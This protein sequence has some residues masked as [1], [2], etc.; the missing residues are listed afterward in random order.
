VGAQQ[1]ANRKSKLVKD[2]IFYTSQAKAECVVETYTMENIPAF[3]EEDYMTS[4]N[5][6]LSAIRYE[7]ETFRD[8]RGNVE[9]YSKSWK[10]V[11]KDFKFGEGTG[12]ES[13]KTSYFKNF[14]SDD[15][16]A[17]PNTVE[18]AKSV[19]YKLQDE[20][21]W[22]KKNYIFRDENVK[23]AYET[24]SGST[25]ELNLILLNFLN[26]S[27][28]DAQFMVLSTRENGVPTKLYPIISEFNYLVVK[29][30]I[31]GSTY[32]LDITDKHTPFGTLPFKTLNGYGRVMDFKE[33]SYWYDFSANVE[34]LQNTIIQFDIESDGNVLVK[35]RE[36]NTGY[37]ALN[38]R[39]K[40]IGRSTD[41]YLEE[42]ENDFDK[43]S[44]LI[45]EDYEVTNKE[46]LEKSLVEVFNLK[47]DKK[48]T[49]D[50][51]YINPFITNKFHKNPFNL[52]DRTYPVDFGYPFTYK[53]QIILNL[54]ENFTVED[55][56]ESKTL[57]LY[58]D[59]GFLIYQTTKNNNQILVNLRFIINK[60]LFT[61]NEYNDL[62]KF[63]SELVFLQNK[64]LIHIKKIK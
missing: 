15:I 27:G 57:K 48:F 8:F 60:S 21:Y 22:N 53:Y 25:A 39:N 33:G 32:L 42:L 43:D 41:D 45:I 44:D 30:D 63:F 14:I 58:D 17:A 50:H 61:P 18:K 47:L 46:D 34:S 59:A 16:I 24:K 54:S 49:E 40:I 38:K 3:K 29:L 62:K 56:P 55:L 52:E 51:F 20:L 35:V 1:L 9:K 6:Y 12:K 10:D 19:Y 11:D 36:S 4:K 23:D 26:A 28:F 7:L 5:N 37:F 31:D 13:R 2:C 64:Q